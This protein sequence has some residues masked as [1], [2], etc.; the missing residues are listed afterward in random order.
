[1][2]VADLAARVRQNS[3]NSGKPPSQDGLAKPAPKSLRKKTVA[4]RS[5]SHDGVAQR[6]RAL[7][8]QGRGRRF[9]AGRH[10]QEPPCRPG[11]SPK[12][13]G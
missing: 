3:G 11:R 1:M 9:E 2:R 12:R 7:P 6:V 8:C 10:R 5:G 13:S 4:G